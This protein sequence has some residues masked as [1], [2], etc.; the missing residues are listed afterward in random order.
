[1]G[2][3]AYSGISACSASQ[4]CHANVCYEFSVWNLFC[5]SIIPSSHLDAFILCVQDE[6][7]KTWREKDEQISMLHH[8]V[9]IPAHII[10]VIAQ[11]KSVEDNVS[12]RGQYSTALNLLTCKFG[13]NSSKVLDLGIRLAKAQVH[14]KAIVTPAAEAGL[15]GLSFVSD[16]PM[17]DYLQYP[18][19]GASTKERHVCESSRYVPLCACAC[20]LLA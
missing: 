6:S 14:R 20:V 3:L 7:T 18:R 11:Y 10:T 13:I 19:A 4:G 9:C 1:M 15:H 2:F 17:E 16:L 5:Y 12:Q 8:L